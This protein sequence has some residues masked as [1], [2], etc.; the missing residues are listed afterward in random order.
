MKIAG[1]SLVT[2]T[3]AAVVEGLPYLAGFARLIV[4]LEAKNGTQAL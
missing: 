4:H 1:L 3:A 2:A